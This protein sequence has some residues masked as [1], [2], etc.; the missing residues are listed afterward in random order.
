MRPRP[1][2]P[3]GVPL[4]I[5][6]VSPTAIRRMVRY[7]DGWYVIGKDLDEYRSHM[8]ALSEECFRQGRNPKELEITAYWN[9][10]QEGLESLS[11]YEDLGVHRLLINVHALRERDVNTAMERFAENVIAKRG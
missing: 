10:Y 9:Y 11:V 6:G 3:G 2:Q 1:A 7:G 8:K 4:V 5:G